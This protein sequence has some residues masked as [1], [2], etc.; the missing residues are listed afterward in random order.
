M[1]TSSSTILGPTEFLHSPRCIPYLSHMP[2]FITIELHN[3]DVI[4]RRP[5]AGGRAGATLA[6]MRAREHG[7]GADALPVIVGGKRLDL[8]SRVGHE[9]QKSL[10]PFCVLFQ[11]LHVS[12]R[13]RLRGK[14]S[15]G[16][17]I[18]VALVPPFP[19]FASLKELHGCLFNRHHRSASFYSD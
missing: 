17:T 18:T 16:R 12:E 10:H 14:S 9:R 13:L 5:L 8:I 1:S 2:D 7:V 4:A 19:L 6:G 11:A 15:I 3:V